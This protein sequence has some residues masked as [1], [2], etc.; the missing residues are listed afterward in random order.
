MGGAEAKNISATQVQR[1]FW[2]S[3]VLL[4]NS[5]H[6][7]IL[8]M[9]LVTQK[10]ISMGCVQEQCREEAVARTGMMAAPPRRLHHTYPEPLVPAQ[11]LRRTESLINICSVT[12][13]TP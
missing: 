2:Y 6:F 9:S 10:S 7:V 8:S 3:R 12:E 5:L 11:Y 4:W 1:R 13:W